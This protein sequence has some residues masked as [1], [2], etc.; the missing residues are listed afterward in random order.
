MSGIRT[1][2]SC[3][4]SLFLL[5][6]LLLFFFFLFRRALVEIQV[7][8]CDHMTYA[9]IAVK[10]PEEYAAR[11]ADKLN[12]R[13]PQGGE[14]Y[15]D[16]IAR[17]EPCILE[18]E[19]MCTP[20][21]LVVHRA[22]AR[23]FYSYFL[24]LSPTEIPHLDIPLH[25]VLKL[26][27]KAYGCDVTRYKLG[28]ESVDDKQCSSPKPNEEEKAKKQMIAEAFAQ[29]KQAEVTTAETEQRKETVVH[30]NETGSPSTN[31]DKQAK[32]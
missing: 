17:I 26:V 1:Q 19:R 27:P 14:S 13:Y 2:S 25:T 6:L 23:C 15:M 20:V 9:E 12:Y 11:S 8:N 7:G 16:V 31:S 32:L 28:V 4:S 10:Y 24:D 30:I 22:V 3:I 21:L 5:L 18:L 29:A